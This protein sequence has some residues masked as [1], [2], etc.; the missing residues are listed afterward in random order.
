MS[1]YVRK[2]H[3]VSI[4]LYHIVCP[5]KYRR[6]VV[7]EEVDNTIKEI[8]EEISKRYEMNLPAALRRGGSF[9]FALFV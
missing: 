3:S 4:L 2:R 6:I 7:N 5:A 8:C 1:E 9:D